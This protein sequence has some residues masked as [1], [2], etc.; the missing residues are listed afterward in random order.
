MGRTS[1]AKERLIRAAMDLFF[2][3]SYTAVGV[4]ELCKAA[5]VKKG[6]FLPLL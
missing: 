1:D 2:T 6:K 3:R 4:Q 5:A